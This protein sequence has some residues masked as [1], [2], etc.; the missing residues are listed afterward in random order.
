MSLENIV[1]YISKQTHY[2][3]MALVGGV[4]PWDVLPVVFAME[5]LH[6]EPSETQL[7]GES[8]PQARGAAA[9]SVAARG[10]D[11]HAE[12]PGGPGRALRR[13]A[14]GRLCTSTAPESAARRCRRPRPGGGCARTQA[15]ARA[16]ALATRAHASQNP[17]PSAGR[18]A[19]HDGRRGPGPGGSCRRGL[20]LEAGGVPETLRPRANNKSQNA[21]PTRGWDSKSKVTLMKLLMRMSTLE[22]SSRCEGR[23]V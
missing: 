12:E 20:P 15:P 13:G 7:R 5:D 1:C 17:A 23:V 22:A 19:G 6:G 14:A 8:G 9:E 2:F 21:L 4:R 16:P 11:P 10:D 3:V 18:R